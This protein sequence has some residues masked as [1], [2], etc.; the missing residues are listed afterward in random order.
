MKWYETGLGKAAVASVVIAVIAIS[1]FL[2]L[3]IF[4]PGD[5][6]GP[7]TGPQ[8]GFGARAADYLNSR[9]DDVVFYWMCNSSFVNNRLTQYYQQTEPDAYV[10]GVR[11]SKYAESGTIEVLF[12][13]YSANITGHGEVSLDDW[14]TLSGSLVDDAIALMPD[15]ADH[16]DDFPGTWPIDFY[17]S[18]FFDD[19]TF[20]Y[21]GYTQSDQM[22]F[23]QNGTWTGE[24]TEYGHPEI[25][26]RAETGY[27]L[28]AN[29]LMTDPM[30]DFYNV[31][32]ENVAY[33]A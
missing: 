20:F 10:D 25:T 26:G 15:A 28:D 16:P 8:T 14:G 22:V 30:D 2:A 3:S 17:V 21:I 9:R 7:P 24:L 4:L 33:P 29:G 12:A 13:P 19:N 31:I 18:I 23:L 5:E 32:T 27:W 6:T 1:G 11:M